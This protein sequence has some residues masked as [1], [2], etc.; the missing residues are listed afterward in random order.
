[1]LSSNKQCASEKEQRESSGLSS[2]RNSY[3]SNVDDELNVDI[4][5]APYLALILPETVRAYLLHLVPPIIEDDPKYDFGSMSFN[6]VIPDA[7]YNEDA[8]HATP[9][10]GNPDWTAVNGTRS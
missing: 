2:T 7:Y 5:P 9:S 3:A 8:H 1:M 4:A 6:E 10:S